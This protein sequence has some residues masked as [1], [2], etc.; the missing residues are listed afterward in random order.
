MLLEG[1]KLKWLFFD[2]S[3]SGKKFA[4]IPFK[5]KWQPAAVRRFPEKAKLKRYASEQR[6]NPGEAVNQC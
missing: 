3:D 1:E 2:G 4:E 6:P 5:I